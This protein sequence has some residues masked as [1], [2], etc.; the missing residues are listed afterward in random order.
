[1][2]HGY[3]LG[4]TPGGVSLGGPSNLINGNPGW[5]REIDDLIN[6]AILESE[7]GVF[8]DAAGEQIGHFT[9]GQ[10]CFLDDDIS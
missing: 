2:M 5:K 4:A 10:F 6:K 1:M 7:G 3:K 9:R 8:R